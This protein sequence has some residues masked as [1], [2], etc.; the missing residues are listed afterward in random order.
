MCSKYYVYVTGTARGERRILLVRQIFNM[1]R[2]NG[3]SCPRVDFYGAQYQFILDDRD[4]DEY[5]KTP[6]FEQFAHLR[7]RVQKLIVYSDMPTTLTIVRAKM[8]SETSWTPGTP[9]VFEYE[10]KVNTNMNVICLCHTRDCDERPEPYLRVTVESRGIGLISLVPTPDLDCRWQALVVTAN[11]P[12]SLAEQALISTGFHYIR[13]GSDVKEWDS[14]DPW[15]KRAHEHF[16]PGFARFSLTEAQKVLLWYNSSGSRR[17]SCISQ[18]KDDIG[19]LGQALCARTAYF[20][21]FDIQFIIDHQ[22]RHRWYELQWRHMIDN[23]YWESVLC[24]H[25]VFDFEDWYGE[26]IPRVLSTWES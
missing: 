17:H 22:D 13:R 21:A 25:G 9:N 6:K 24:K 26:D 5:N 14:Q 11:S 7:Q 2:G 19:H 20:R 16:A 18:M 12:L 4:V 1:S 8:W 3:A 23:P 10:V 15:V